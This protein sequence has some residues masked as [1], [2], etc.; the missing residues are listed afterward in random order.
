MLP[1]IA[2]FDIVIVDPSSASIAISL[3][4]ASSSVLVK[5]KYFYD[6]I[7]TNILPNPPDVYR[8]VQGKVSVNA[9]VTSL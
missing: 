7:A 4:P 5:P 3:H 6:I 2:N 1:D 8:L 9:A